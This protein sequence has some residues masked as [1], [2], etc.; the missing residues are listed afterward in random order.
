MTEPMPIIIRVKKTTEAQDRATKRWREKN[1]E[2]FVAYQKEYQKNYQPTYQ[3]NYEY[4]H[5]TYYKL[6]TEKRKAQAKKC[7]VMKREF[8]R[9]RNILL[10]IWHFYKI[11]CF[12]KIGWFFGVFFITKNWLGFLEK[13]K[14]NNKIYIKKNLNR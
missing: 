11:V 14:Y 6:N 4:D 3:A 7:Y 2:L 5:K 1:H 10:D 13:W 12:I 9:L 8:E